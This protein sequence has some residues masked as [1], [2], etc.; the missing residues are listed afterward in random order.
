MLEINPYGAMAGHEL[1]ALI[2]LH[3][4]KSVDVLEVCPAYST[5]MTEAKK[6]LTALKSSFATSV[7]FGDTELAEWKWFARVD[8][9]RHGTEVLAETLPLAICR[10]ALLQIDEAGVTLRRFF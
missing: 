10:L 7:T 1:D 4:M 6:V 9:V 5:E 8:R 3:V 2:H